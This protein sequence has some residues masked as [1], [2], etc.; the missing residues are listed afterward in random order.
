MERTDMVK[1]AGMC[2]GMF[3]PE[4][5]IN[6]ELDDII[7]LHCKECGGMLLGDKEFDSGYCICCGK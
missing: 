4:P 2:C 6:H 3:P 7:D 5:T 1:Y